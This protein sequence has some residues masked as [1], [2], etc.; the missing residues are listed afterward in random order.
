MEISKF[1]TTMLAVVV[2]AIMSSALYVMKQTYT[3]NTQILSMPT[4]SSALNSN[5]SLSLETTNKKYL[6]KLGNWAIIVEFVEG[7]KGVLVV[8]YVGEKP[9]I[10]E[11]PLLPPIAGLNVI[12]SYN[13][14][15]KNTVVRK[16][17]TY[18]YNMSVEIKPG[19]ESELS[20]NAK[21]LRL[22]RVEGKILGKIPVKIMLP[23]CS[24]A[25]EKYSRIVT[26]TVTKTVTVVANQTGKATTTYCEFVKEEEYLEPPRG[27]LVRIEIN[28]E[29]IISDETLRIRI[30]L[31]V[32][33]PRIPLTFENIQN[34]PL[35]VPANYV[36]YVVLNATKDGI[37]Y[38]QLNYKVVYVV[39]V[40]T[41]SPLPLACS[42]KQ[43]QSTRLLNYESVNILKPGEKATLLKLTI[44]TN[45]NELKGFDEGWV[46]VK[47]KIKYAPI[48]EV[49]KI[50]T[51][52]KYWTTSYLKYYRAISTYATRELEIVFRVHVRFS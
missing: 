19:S 43:P 2:L 14:P 1:K 52:A 11:N 48:K 44:P 41:T 24:E 20:F 10:V 7:D 4:I 49:Y 17:G 39:P 18:Y 45:I 46:Y 35:W 42:E 15:S 31:K 8:K 13:D 38:V 12:L 36:E 22:M 29:T 27:S 23:I 5:S 9:L 25:S 28:N 37:H 51:N 30:P 16:S 47:A 6:F 26:V 33:K 50:D 34:T 32:L 21:G 40:T 3:T